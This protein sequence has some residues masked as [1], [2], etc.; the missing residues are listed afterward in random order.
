MNPYG[1]YQ[2]PTGWRFETIPQLVDDTGLFVDGDWI[3]TKDQNPD[4][5]VRLIQLADIGDGEFRD[6]SHRFLTSARAR[7]LGCTFLSPEM[8]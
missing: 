3:E 8:S 2:L 4:G 7:E 1:G 5:D 6:R